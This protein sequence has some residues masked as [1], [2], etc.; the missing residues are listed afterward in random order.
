LV[1]PLLLSPLLALGLA[2]LLYPLLHR[3]RV[4]MGI[5]RETCLCVGEEV[6][7][8]A[9][10]PRRGRAA[11]AGSGP[12]PTLTVGT[13]RGCFERYGG[14]LVGIN[15]QTAMD[16]LHYLSAG[17]VSFARG[18]NDTPKIVALMIAVKAFHLPLGLGLVG[19]AIALGGLFGTRRVAETMSHRITVMNPGQGLT[20]N[21]VTA[22]LVLFASNLGM[23]VSTTHVSCGALFGIGAASGQAR[24]R[25]IG[26]ILLA[27]ITTLPVAV[28]LAAVAGT[29][30]PL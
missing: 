12:L 10:E 11:V 2:G 24:W 15:A 29:V 13:D 6:R 27:W 5:T 23:P 26:A 14:S 18:L 21:L 30:L 4:T 17:A 16:R 20:A 7:V 8:I 22:G 28:A 9:M 19:I 25:M 3:L 1:L